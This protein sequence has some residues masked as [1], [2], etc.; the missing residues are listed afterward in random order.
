M[1]NNPPIRPARFWYVVGVALFLAGMV[2][3]PVLLVTS[4]LE[5]VSGGE[6]FIVPGQLG[7]TIEK[8]GSYTLW[9]DVRTVYKG[10]SYNSSESLP[11][12]VTIE[13]VYLETREKVEFESDFGT[14]QHSGHS[15]SVAIGTFKAEQPGRYSINV[16]NLD[17]KRVFHVQRSFFELLVSRILVA[18]II[19]PIGFFG[20]P[21]IVIITAI[22]RKNA[23]S[24]QES[25]QAQA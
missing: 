2:G 8:P 12:G 22:R 1:E 13:I 23:R 24:R 9:Y 6:Q 20:G 19:G 16:S 15:F 14:T 4:V 7:I 17:E 18:V 3:A 25:G 5:M 10:R 21:A 11:D